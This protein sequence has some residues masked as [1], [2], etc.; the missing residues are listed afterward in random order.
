[1]AR[2]QRAGAEHRIARLRVRMDATAIDRVREFLQIHARTLASRVQ[3]PNTLA[4]EASNESVPVRN[5]AGEHRRRGPAPSAHRH[6][7]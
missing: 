3:R 2:P 1:M 5:E 7:P 4:I 6:A